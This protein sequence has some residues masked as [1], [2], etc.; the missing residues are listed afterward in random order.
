MNARAVPLAAAVASV[1]GILAA[2][3]LVLPPPAAAAPSD[4][5]SAVFQCSTRDGRTVFSDEPCVGAPHVRVWTPRAGTQGIERSSS[6]APAPAAMVASAMG[7]GSNAGPAAYGPY[8]DCQRRGGRFDVAARI[9]HLPDDAAR[10]MFD[11]K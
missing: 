2:L 3:A 4:V 10:Q 5:P 7:Y 6:S 9:C 11:A 8:V 1:P